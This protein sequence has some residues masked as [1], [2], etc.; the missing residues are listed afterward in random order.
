MKIVLSKLK[1]NF[2]CKINTITNYRFY[3]RYSKE[4]MLSMLNNLK[5]IKM[6]QK[7][8]DYLIIQQYAT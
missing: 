2:Y 6:S 7:P 1:L 4:N 8:K 3:K 5:T